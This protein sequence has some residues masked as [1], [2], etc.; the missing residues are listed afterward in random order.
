MKSTGHSD[1]RPLVT[2]LRPLKDTAMMFINGPI[3]HRQ[4]RIITRYMTAIRTFSLT[5]ILMLR[6]MPS[7]PHHSDSSVSLRLSVFAT[8]ISRKLTAELNSP[9]AVE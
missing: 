8:R 5:A 7:P 3:T 1:T 6:F 2:A 9:T 4:N